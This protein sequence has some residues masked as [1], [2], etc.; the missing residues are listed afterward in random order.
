MRKITLTESQLHNLIKESIKSILKESYT[1]F[2]DDVEISTDITYSDNRIDRFFY[3]LYDSVEYNV[4]ELYDTV[5][6][7]VNIQGTSEYFSGSYD[8]PPYTNEE[9]D[10]YK[11]DVDI[12]GR[13]KKIMP[14]DL[15]KTFVN[16]IR[17]YIEKNESDYINFE[18][19]E[20]DTYDE[21]RDS[22]YD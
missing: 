15:Y 14:E 8:E 5:T 12:D 21:W 16:D 4:F 9:F 19:Y 22:R 3:D 20:P 1:S 7:H 17:K 6:C 18:D 2:E 10:T 13:F 11:I